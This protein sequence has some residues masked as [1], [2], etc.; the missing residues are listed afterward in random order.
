[1]NRTELQTLIETIQD[2]VPNTAETVRG[3][4]TA[5]ADGI[6]DRVEMR[7]VSTSYISANFD[8]TGIRICNLQW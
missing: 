7:E 1:M 4:L 5:I 2:G 8:P 3:V 6:S